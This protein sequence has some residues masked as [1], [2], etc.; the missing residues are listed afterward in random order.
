MQHLRQTRSLLALVG[1]LLCLGASLPLLQALQEDDGFSDSPYLRID[2]EKIVLDHRDSKTPC[3]ECHAL[4][5][6]AWSTTA[7]ATGFDELHRRERAQE[8]LDNLDLNSTKRASLCLRCHYTAVGEGES[9][10]AIAGVSCES[11]HGAARDWIDVHND[12]GTQGQTVAVRRELETD[13]HRA[14][15]IEASI[16]GGMLRPEESLYA[17]AANCFEC[18]TVPDENLVNEG[19]HV[20]GSGTFD[21][22]RRI[23]EIQHNFVAAQW[24][25]DQSNAEPTPER[26]RM[27]LVLGRLLDYEYSLRGMAE[28]TE[29]GKYAKSMERRASRAYR[30][31]DAAYKAVQAPE[32]AEVL[33]I[34]SDLVLA[35]GREADLAAAANEISE[36]SQLF[37]QNHDGSGLAALD[38][39]LGGSAPAVAEAEPEAGTPDDTEGAPAPAAESAAAPATA[40]SAPPAPQP[41]VEV[42]TVTED[43]LGP[44]RQRPAWFEPNGPYETIAPGC[45]CHGEAEDWWYE[46]EHF[47]S[48]DPLLNEAPRAVEIATAYG[49][50]AEQMKRG[51]QLCMNCHGT[52]LTGDEAA[53]VADG[54]SCESC[55]GPSSGYLDPHENGG[56]PQ[57][58]MKALKQPAVRAANCAQCHLITEPRLLAA[59]HPSGGDYDMVAANTDIKHWPSRTVERERDGPYPEADDGALASAF[60]TIAQQRPIPDVDVR[61]APPPVASVPAQT[62]TPDPAGTSAPPAATSPTAS[63]PRSAPPPARTPQPPRRTQ[64]EVALDLPP[65]PATGDSTST[66]DLLL[67]VKK[68]LELLHEAIR[69]N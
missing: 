20:A 11:C 5:Y 32:L 17:V 29:Q 16:S 31:I 15:R 40:A 49:L 28:A 53:P 58:G 54:V 68:R 23:G 10:K 14:Q 3:G 12:Y 59:G 2:P 7:H 60:L 57:L 24:S 26:Q 61:S 8:I 1:S 42:A 43:D 62:S 4:E 63:T 51:D 67:I 56:N 9:V 46:D 18:H 30:E 38:R 48:A 35:P 65:L 25:D 39:F 45:S 69:N 13:E 44:I 52:V 37:A 66:E 64:S 19:G 41:D 36:Q 50:T 33:R 55:H 27:M 21:L 6:D 34:G 47:A 22:V